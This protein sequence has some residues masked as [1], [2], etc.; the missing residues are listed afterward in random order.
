MAAASADLAQPSCSHRGPSTL[1]EAKVLDWETIRQICCD[2][3]IDV[4]RCIAYLETKDSDTLFAALQFLSPSQWS[5]AVEAGILRGIDGYRPFLAFATAGLWHVRLRFSR[6]HPEHAVM[7]KKLILQLLSQQVI[8]GTGGFQPAADPDALVRHARSIPV[9]TV[10]LIFMKLVESFPRCRIMIYMYGMKMFAPAFLHD[11]LVP[12]IGGKG[13]KGYVSLDFGRTFLPRFRHDMPAIRAVAPQRRVDVEASDHMAD[14]TEERRTGPSHSGAP[15]SETVAV[16]PVRGPGSVPAPDPDG[17]T[18]A[19]TS[20]DKVKIALAGG[21][22]RVFRTSLLSPCD[23]L[24]V[25]DAALLLQRK[26][27]LEEEGYKILFYTNLGEEMPTSLTITADRYKAS[28]INF[29][30]LQ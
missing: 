28:S 20:H 13:L 30:N 17:G 29:S 25:W 3:F 7:A 12:L 1:P 18:T 22:M 2:D 4:D 23:R 19:A 27:Q 10:H 16:A 15:S 26:Q 9:E 8:E 21:S 14:D 11:W 6:D 5:L 24:Y